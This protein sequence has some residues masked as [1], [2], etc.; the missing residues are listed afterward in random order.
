MLS[1]A[2][3]AS[4]AAYTRVRPNG[5]F[6]PPRVVILTRYIHYVESFAKEA[7][8]APASGAYL[9]I[10]LYDTGLIQLSMAGSTSG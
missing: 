3:C 9:S 10:P 2:D 6:V 4:G 8:R 7:K 5:P 1:A